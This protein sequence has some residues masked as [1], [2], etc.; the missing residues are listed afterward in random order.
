MNIKD[1]TEKLKN[2]V[3]EKEETLKEEETKE[4]TKPISDEVEDIPEASEDSKETEE[5]DDIK[6]KTVLVKE[7]EQEVPEDRKNKIK[8]VVKI[9]AGVGIAAIGIAALF[10]KSKNKK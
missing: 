8:D 10:F 9:A 7:E 2:A 1:I 3:E 6:I 5:K 4:E